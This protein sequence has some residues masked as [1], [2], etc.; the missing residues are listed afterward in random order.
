M[1]SNGRRTDHSIEEALFDRGYEFEFFQA[2]RLLAQLL[3]HRK[4][5]GGTAKPG[6]EFV[7]FGAQLSMAFPASAVHDIERIPDSPNSALMTVAFLALT[8]T[9]GVLPFYY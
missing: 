8:G 4:G 5:V 9:Q 6:E 3:P 7:R 1:G 2:V